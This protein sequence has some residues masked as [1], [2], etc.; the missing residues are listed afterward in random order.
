[1]KYYS[2][3][4][5]AIHLIQ[6]YDGRVPFAVYLKKYFALHKKYGSKDRKSIAH[7]CYCYFR[8]GKFAQPSAANDHILLG[9]WLC[10]NN[11]TD[12]LQTLAPDLN[13]SANLP[14]RE[15]L[16]LPAAAGIAEALFPFQHLLSEGV[17][18]DAFMT[19]FFTQ[20]DVFL[21]IRPGAGNI[22]ALLESQQIP[23]RTVNEQTIAIPNT[24]KIDTLLPLN[25]EVVIQDLSS[26]QTGRVLQNHLPVFPKNVWDCCAASGGKSIMMKDIFPSFRLTVSDLR[27]SIL[28]NLQKR[29]YQAGIRQYASFVADLTQP[30]QAENEFDL[31]FAD[32]PCTGSGTWARTPEQLVFFDEAAIE[33]YARLQAEIVRNII[34]A[35]QPGGYLAYC[36]CSVFK[37]E[38]EQQVSL[39]IRQQPGLKLVHQQTITG[40][41]EK[42]DSLFI[43]ILQRV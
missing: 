26:Q 34:P 42:A 40:Y 33:R 7:L 22:P 10:T 1:M 18:S 43:A 17:E 23:Y 21:R 39:F 13:E 35:I 11:M 25:K 20:P 12:L 2:H 9:Y 37:Q 14:L 3:L 41:H 4:Q 28:M 29:F 6:G 31:I 27:S 30:V 5:T 15:K 36:T 8:L 24:V 32:V 19:S 38:N 16:Q